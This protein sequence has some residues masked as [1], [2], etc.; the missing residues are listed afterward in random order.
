ML[1]NTNRIKFSVN[2]S[3][4]K[5]VSHRFCSTTKKFGKACKIWKILRHRSRHYNIKPQNWLWYYWNHL[6]RLLRSQRIS[7]KKMRGGDKI[8]LGSNST[9]LPRTSTINRKVTIKV[10]HHKNML[11]LR[12]KLSNVTI[13][14]CLLL[15]PIHLLDITELIY[16][17]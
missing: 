17:E 15:L 14:T 2:Q 1:R 10:I 7:H 5:W 6:E 3:E 4:E 8:L 9:T 13:Y 16:P 12:F 11:F